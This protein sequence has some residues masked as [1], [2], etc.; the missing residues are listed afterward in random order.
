MRR[1]LLPLLLLAL[2][3]APLPARADSSASAVPVPQRH[4]PA[5]VLM[6]LRALEGQFDL[7][8]RHDCAPER[9]VSK[10]CFYRD[11]VVVDLPRSSS[12]PGLGQAEGPG[13]VPAQEYLTQAHCEL[14]HEKSV[15][16]R[17]VQ[18]LV[19]RLEQRLSKGWLK[20]T[21]GREILEPISPAL[22]ESPAPPPEPQPPARPEVPPAPP[23]P[24]PPAKWEA[25]VALRELWVALLPHFSWMIAVA[26]VTLSALLIIWGLRRLG[27]ESLEEK[28]MAAQLA[29]GVLGKPEEPS[30]LDPAPATTEASETEVGLEA[31]EKSAAE[32][33]EAK[34]V[35]E[36]RRL[37]TDRIAQAEL[38]KEDGVVVELLRDWLKS[39]EYDLL[40]KAILVFGD[41][42]SLAFAS[43]GELA[44]R[45]VELADHLRNLDEA[46]LPSDAEFFRRLAHHSISSTLLAQ[47]DADTYRSLREEFGSAGVA[48]L[49]ERQSP[50]HGGLLFALAPA[51]LQSEVA[52]ILAPEVRVELAGQLLVSNRISE[53]ERRHL[54][55]VLDAA[56]CGAPLPAPPPPSPNGIPDRGREID[57]AGAL[58]R[59]F[60]FIEEGE[61]V[62]LFSAALQRS[63]GAFPDWYEGILYPDMLMKI[64]PE[65]RADLV[66]DLD[67]QGLAAWMSQQPPAWQETFMS[68]LASTMQAAVRA[69]MSFASRADQLRMA[70]QGHAELVSA[71]RKLA[72]RGRVSFAELMA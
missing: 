58:S 46:R 65:L 16:P 35:A 9:C 38:A 51:E 29:A 40:A 41:R 43:D 68:G 30:Q 20:V 45:K 69:N 33:E 39:R 11:H 55:A 54:F 37:W 23:A 13:S 18:A 49:L 19:K 21:V 70:R 25:G 62:S 61:R 44:A 36:Q 34:L 42:L 71:V 59:L 64:P 7:A 15:S 24:T 63:S 12:L 5:P 8:L 10:G 47:S 17:D 32:A 14:A 3:A 57:A 53:E 2:A 66:L 60:P 26:L 52:R 27:R 72:A 4:V 67:V 1:S 31:D 28:A 50:R 6:E 56:R 48:G 22:S